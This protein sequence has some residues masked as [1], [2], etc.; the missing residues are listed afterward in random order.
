MAVSLPRAEAGE[1]LTHDISCN[2]TGYQNFFDWNR[3]TRMW[4]D[5]PDFAALM[6]K[7]DEC[8]KPYEPWRTDYLKNGD[9]AVRALEGHPERQAIQQCHDLQL[10]HE[11]WEGCVWNKWE[12]RFRARKGNKP[13]FEETVERDRGY[14][15]NDAGDFKMLDCYGRPDWRSEGQKASGRAMYGK[16]AEGRVEF[17]EKQRHREEGKRAADAESPF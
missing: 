17:L 16:Y 8:R 13:T 7:Y 4:R 15:C 11:W 6:G 1:R 12:R 14:R 9:Y 10:A 5:L 2:N 3:T